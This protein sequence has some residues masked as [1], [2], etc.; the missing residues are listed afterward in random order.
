MNQG[1]PLCMTCRLTRQDEVRAYAAGLKKRR[2]RQIEEQALWG[3]ANPEP[4]KRERGPSAETRR[5]A[6]MFKAIKDKHPDWSYA[7][8]AREATRSA[9]AQA[10]LDEKPPTYKPD[11]VR[12][13][14]RAMGWVWRPA[15]RVQ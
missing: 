5:R 6:E 3:E 9:K 10:G 1:F 7:R 15:R 12:N 13:A 2:L 8:V 11:D 4:P 14:Y